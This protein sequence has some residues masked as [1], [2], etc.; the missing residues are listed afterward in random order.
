MWLGL[1]Q[2]GANL[3]TE[4]SGLALPLM[5]VALVSACLPRVTSPRSNA[6]DDTTTRT[7][8]RT[9]DHSH[10]GNSRPSVGAWR[11]SVLPVPGLRPVAA[12]YLTYTVGFQ[13]MAGGG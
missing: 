1:R 6:H 13:Y 7:N 2:Y 3:M 10:G 5:A 8:A 4:T 9:G 11:A 12:A